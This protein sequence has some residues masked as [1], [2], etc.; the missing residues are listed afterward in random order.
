MA[1]PVLLDQASNQIL[2]GL[3][4]LF[5]RVEE[6]HVG[7]HDAALFQRMEDVVGKL[8]DYALSRKDENVNDDRFESPDASGHGNRPASIH[9]R[10]DTRDP[11]ETARVE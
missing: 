11:L 2:R 9:L 5:K 1:A 4:A 7:Q 10:A 6:N 8:V 3:K